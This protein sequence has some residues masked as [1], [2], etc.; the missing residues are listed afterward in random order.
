[1]PWNKLRKIIISSFSQFS[2]VSTEVISM[3]NRLISYNLFSFLLKILFIP[4][5]VCPMYLFLILINVHL[6][7]TDSWLILAFFGMLLYATINWCIFNYICSGL[8]F[9]YVRFQQRKN[10]IK[11]SFLLRYN[12]LSKIQTEISPNITKI[13]L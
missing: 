9:F 8:Y 11:C 12:T 4:Y 5:L 7:C 1:M 2:N 13:Y 10:K 3:F 6:F